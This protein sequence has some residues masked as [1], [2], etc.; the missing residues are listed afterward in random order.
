MSLRDF[1]RRLLRASPCGSAVVDGAA[2]RLRA[3]TVA[4]RGAGNGMNGGGGRVSAA[5]S[6]MR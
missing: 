2:L 5:G 4:W 3:G 6:A 1:E